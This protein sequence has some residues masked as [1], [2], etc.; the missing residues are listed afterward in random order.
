MKYGNRDCYLLIT[1]LSISV[2]FNLACSETFTNQDP[3]GKTFPTLKGKSL[4]KKRWNLPKD[5]EGRFVV[6]LAGYIQETQFDIDRWLI[7]LD[8]RSVK[9]QVYELPTIKGMIPRLISSRI[10]EGMRSG[11]P[12][13]L[14]GGVITIYQDG[15]KM[16]QFTGNERPR[17]ARVILLD[18]NSK[19]HF[20]TDKGFSVGGLN[21]LISI[22][23][24]LKR[25]AKSLPSSLR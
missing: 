5:F 14:W 9:T 12:P 21:R 19:I 1:L 8:M 6:L 16:Q 23:D 10:N 13:E 18:P 4:D 24:Q 11:I 22:L 25:E 17:N 20:F 15:G 7:G 2:F 3:T